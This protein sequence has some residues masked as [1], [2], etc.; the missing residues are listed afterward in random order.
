VIAIW[1]L[2]RNGIPAADGGFLQIMMATRGNTEMERLVLRDQLIT[3]E[4]MPA[5]LKSLQIRYGN[6][7]GEEML[8]VEGSRMGFG[9]IGETASLRKKK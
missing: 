3:T 1:S 7:V 8:G 6:L 9:T 4:N 2:S 5:E